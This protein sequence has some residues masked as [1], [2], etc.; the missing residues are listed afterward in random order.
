MMAS[1]KASISP[2]DILCQHRQSTN[3]RSSDE[4][5]VL[6]TKPM[7]GD[8]VDSKLTRSYSTHSSSSFHQ[9]PW[10]HYQEQYDVLH[11]RLQEPVIAML[12]TDLLTTFHITRSTYTPPGRQMFLQLIA[13]FA[14]TSSA[15][16]G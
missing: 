15:G 4:D 11:C 7:A 3:G 12:G 6:Q 16:F 2:E 10:M 8:E 14:R 13:R 9:I 1:S 5:A